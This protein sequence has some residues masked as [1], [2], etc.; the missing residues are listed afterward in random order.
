MAHY[1]SIYRTQLHYKRPL[2][3]NA[4]IVLFTVQ[5]IVPSDLPEPY[6]CFCDAKDVNPLVQEFM[7]GQT[8]RSKALNA[9]FQLRFGTS[10]PDYEPR[11]IQAAVEA[12]IKWTNRLDIG[13]KVDLAVLDRSVGFRWIEVKKECR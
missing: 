9:E 11:R 7:A 4:T 10:S 12:A 6:I 5:K 8:P 1:T 13:G 2:G 3:S